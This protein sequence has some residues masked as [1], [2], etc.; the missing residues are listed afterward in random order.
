MLVYILINN[1]LKLLSK[2]DFI[3]AFRSLKAIFAFAF[4]CCNAIDSVAQN[5]QNSWFRATIRVP[6][7][8]NLKTD[9]EW[10]HRRQNNIGNHNPFDQNLLNSFR[11]W[12]FYKQNPNLEWGLSPFA[13]FSSYKTISQ[14]ADRFVDPV[15]EYRFSGAVMLQQNIVEHFSLQMRTMVEFRFFQTSY[16]N[17]T[18]LRNRLMFQYQWN[19]VQS[20]SFGDEVLLHISGVA[21]QHIFDHNRLFLQ[22]SQALG[23]QFKMEL[24]FMHVHKL[25]TAGNQFVIENNWVCNLIYSFKK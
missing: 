20:L 14:P 7:N 25:P 16:P 12:V 4:F 13:Y 22:F 8:E 11:S 9:F 18:R 5:H 10:Q 17:K 24:G 6:L 3:G 19:D 15:G 2:I 23:N 21:P 1:L